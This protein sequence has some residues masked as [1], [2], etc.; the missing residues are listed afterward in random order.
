MQCLHNV[1]A[2]SYM[3][4]QMTEVNIMKYILETVNISKKGGTGYRV[5]DLSIKVPENCVYGFLGPKYADNRK[6]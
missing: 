4:N 5:K 6:A 3:H 1:G 2:L